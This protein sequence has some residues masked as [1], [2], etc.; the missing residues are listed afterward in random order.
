VAGAGVG[1][2]GGGGKRE[3]TLTESERL[4]LAGVGNLGE[5][6]RNGLRGT[7]AAIG[8]FTESQQSERS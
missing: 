6:E 5:D 7:P 1:T 3:D 4:R 2:G 8:I